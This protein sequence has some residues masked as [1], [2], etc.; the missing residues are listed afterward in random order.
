MGKISSYPV[1]TTM[2][3]GDYF[4][5]DS[6]PITENST[7]IIT[8]TN[9]L[10][11]TFVNPLTTL[12]DMIYE[13]A[14]PAAARLAGTTSATK[15]FLTQT[16]TGSL[17]AA[18]AWGTISAGDVPTLNQSTTGNAATATLASALKSATTTVSVSSATAPA[19]GQVLTA[20]NSTTATWQNASTGFANPMNSSGDMIYGGTAGAATRLAKGTNGQVLTLTAG[21]PA[22]A[23]S[24]AGAATY[25]NVKAYGATGNGS[26]DD[27][28][29]IK[30]AITAAIASEATAATVYFPAGTYN[31]SSTLN[32]TG[33][34]GSASGYGVLLR[35]DGHQLS[36]IYKTSSFGYACTWNGNGGPDG[37]NTAFGGM[38]D[39]SIEGNATTGGLVQTNSAQQM[40]F[41]GCSFTGSNGS[42]LDLNTTQDSYFAQCTF[43]SNG[44][45][46]G[47]VINIYGSSTGT[48]NMLYFSQVRV[49]QF[50][51]WAVSVTRGS[52]ATGGGN[53]GFFFSQCKIETAEC[54][55]DMMYFDGYTQQVMMDQMFFSLDAFNGGYS[56]PAN[57]VTFGDG[58]T[59][60][61]ANQ[62]SFSNIFENHASGLANSVI[63]IAPDSGGAM[64]G[65]IV[66]DNIY[67]NQAS[68][69]TALIVANNA[70]AFSFEVG[71]IHSEGATTFGGDGTLAATI[72]ASHIPAARLYLNS[73][74]YID[75]ATA[76]VA[77]L[78]GMMTGTN[79]VTA[80][81]A[82][83]VTTNA[84]TCS[85]SY[86]VNTFT[87]SSSATM[88]ITIPTSGA[89]NGQIM[90]V[91]V[92]DFAGTSETIGW[93]N[94]ENSTVSVP[95]TSNGSTTLPKT[96]T[97]M[98]NSA[99]SKWRCIASA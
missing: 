10:G 64:E 32:C 84:G 75:G 60:S 8:K 33:A 35:G 82:V 87:N 20:T 2:N 37:N 7:S 42:A 99:T 91:R 48:S 13:N 16:G 45:T 86:M 70:G 21:L 36:R 24:A 49:E 72:G 98:Y 90:I 73:T 6:T 63:N 95:T 38:V 80:S 4:L 23:T 58:T 59:G 89:T 53:N 3:A 34:T 55:G 14:T 93:T 27:T 85:V 96:V 74:A 51:K 26:T 62:A 17:S 28:T 69:N 46:S 81:H 71:A 52:G 77:A 39:I 47:A 57:C 65:P 68:I 40:F 22:W 94:T 9:A 54:N 43:N 12:G 18:P 31:I 97:F 88:A 15:Q 50:Y 92:Y 79:F 67:S 78:T 25:F 29:A 19:T 11:A 41:R 66:L 5:I 30:A 56:T 44:T 61:G 1:V 83:T 76:G